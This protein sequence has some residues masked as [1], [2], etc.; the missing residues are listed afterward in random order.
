MDKTKAVL[1]GIAAAGLLG[2]SLLIVGEVANRDSNDAL[3]GDAILS[4]DGG[5]LEVP[6]G[7]CLCPDG[8]PVPN[9]VD[10]LTERVPR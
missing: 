8:S 1:V 9:P 2:G 7:W 3:D 10:C 5:G 6:P 4:D